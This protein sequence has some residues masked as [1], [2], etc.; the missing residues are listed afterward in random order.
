MFVF[1]AVAV[2]VQSCVANV[3]LHLVLL[4]LLNVASLSNTGQRTL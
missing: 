3:L 2:A 4:L 1:D